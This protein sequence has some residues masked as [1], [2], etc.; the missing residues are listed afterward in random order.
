M[1]T[2]NLVYFHGQP[3]SPAE[4]TLAA[5]RPDPMTLFAPDRGSDR[6]DLAFDAYID[7]L[8]D[9]I[10]RRFPSGPLRL[11]GFSMG[12][13]VAMEV[14]IRLTGRALGRDLTLDLIS[15]PAPLETGNYLPRMAGG[16][17]FNL[18]RTAPWAFGFMT[19]L[20]GRLA[21][22]A[23]QVLYGQLFSKAAGADRDLAA[24][25]GFEEMIMDLLESSLRD[26]ARGYR[27]EILAFV[28]S[29]E[30]RL[31]KVTAPVTL[32]QGMADTWTPPDMADALAA[33]LPNLRADRRFPGLSHYS[34]L[35]AALAE[36][37]PA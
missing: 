20:Q 29:G 9:E 28:R 24:T 19:T 26:G 14:S 13:F 8:T 30:G 37:V 15:P 36:I 33:R 34:T 23:P 6:T 4:L 3:G 5:R 21:A 27:R 31:A 32:W 35:K 7:H 25:A 22:A 10:M 1:T 2:P 16:V 11:A 12:A 18:A 17:V